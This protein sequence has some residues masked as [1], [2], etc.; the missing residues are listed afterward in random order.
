MSI[1][2]SPVALFP[3]P[4]QEGLHLDDL[5]HL[6]ALVDWGVALLHPRIKDAYGTYP[7]ESMFKALSLPFL[8]NIPTERA[9]A[10]ELQEKRTLRIVCGFEGEPPT[11]GMLWNFR[12]NP[13]S[14]YSSIMLHVLVA[15]AIAG[16]RLNLSL[17]FIHE[18]PLDEEDKEGAIEFELADFTRTKVK[19]WSNHDVT[20]PIST[21]NKWFDQ[22][23][24]E[25]KE[26][27]KRANQGVN[28]NLDLPAK[29]RIN[30][31]NS[32]A[33]YDFIIDIPEWLD[34][35]YRLTYGLDTLTKISSSSSSS[36]SDSYIACNVLV[37]RN[38]KHGCKQVLLAERL[39]GYGKGEYSLPGGKK[40][41]NETLMQCAK[42][43][44][45]EETGLE[46]LE[47]KPIS[48]KL[49][50]FL[51]RRPTWSIGALATKYTGE[52]RRKEEKQHS[53]WRWYPL[54]SLPSPLFGPARLVIEDYMRTRFENLTWDDIEK[55]AEDSKGIL[56]QPPLFEH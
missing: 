1:Q 55:Q 38:E 37:I 51:N 20:P 32:N 44:L 17:P 43:E 21:S 16:W 3:L 18:A 39:D 50:H 53:D 33:L 48:V 52:P 24:A 10:R 47:S 26:W 9:L 23:A 42:R 29:V 30:F 28:K 7:P 34:S 36:S 2:P 8:I 35:T 12:H 14:L 13:P 11:R 49:T 27:R 6:F 22:V 4:V 15:I 19:V 25:V 54:D 56:T 5:R 41:F 45:L 46:L 31:H 40:R